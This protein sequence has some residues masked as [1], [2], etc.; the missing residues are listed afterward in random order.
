MPHP[1]KTH[2]NSLPHL[3]DTVHPTTGELDQ[4][5]VLAG[6]D[7]WKKAIADGEYTLLTGTE[8]AVPGFPLDVLVLVRRKN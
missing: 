8:F 2:P 3:D 7:A 6:D 4:T 5:A 1:K